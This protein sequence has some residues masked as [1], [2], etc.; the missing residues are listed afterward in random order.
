MSHMSHD[1]LGKFYAWQ[2]RQRTMQ[3][4]L[5][6]EYVYEM[7]GRRKRHLDAN[8]SILSPWNQQTG[9]VLSTLWSS[10]LE[11]D[12]PLQTP[13][14]REQE[15]VTWSPAR[16]KQTRILNPQQPTYI[17]PLRPSSYVRLQLTAHKSRSR[18]VWWDFIRDNL[19]RVLCYLYYGFPPEAPHGEEEASV[20]LHA[21]DT[22]AC[23][24][25]YHLHWATER[26]NRKWSTDESV[27]ESVLLRR[28][29]FL[30]RAP[31]AL[32]GTDGATDRY[33]LVALRSSWQADG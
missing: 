17:H 10:L 16:L 2:T 4:G 12:H 3:T 23:I 5:V 8:F 22:P 7:F 11:L 28:T 25:P 6:Y 15:C 31:Y 1:D 18:E 30:G 24:N 32:W 21:C 19:H 20:A 13:I 27:R 9:N 26:E 29:E 33:A 14:F